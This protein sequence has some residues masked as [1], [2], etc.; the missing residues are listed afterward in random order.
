MT[1]LDK[2]EFRALVHNRVIDKL[3]DHT[4]A[5]ILNRK[6]PEKALRRAFYLYK[7]I[8]LSGEEVDDFS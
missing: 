3:I 1:P 5:L 7:A 8:Y 4:A 2:E 6:D